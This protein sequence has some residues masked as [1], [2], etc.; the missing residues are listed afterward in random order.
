MYLILINILRKFVYICLILG[1]YFTPVGHRRTGLLEELCEGNLSTSTN[2]T[3]R[4]WL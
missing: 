4:F 2:Y 3:P 1:G